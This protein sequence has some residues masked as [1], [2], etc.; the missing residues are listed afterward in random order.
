MMSGCVLKCHYPSTTSYVAYFSL[1]VVFKID[2]D[3]QKIKKKRKFRTL[4]L[5]YLKKKYY[6]C[7]VIFLKEKVIKV[8]TLVRDKR[9]IT[10]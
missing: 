6:Q 9:N 1:F 4:I 8:K 3:Q 7:D 2:D 10:K 5:I